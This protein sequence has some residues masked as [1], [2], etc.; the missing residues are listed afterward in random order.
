MNAKQ[1][2]EANSKQVD[3]LISKL[4]R[5]LKSHRKRYAKQPEHWGYPCDLG[6]VSEL[7]TQIIGFIGE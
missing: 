3:E 4:K 6:A 2:Y 7:L 1:T 5:S